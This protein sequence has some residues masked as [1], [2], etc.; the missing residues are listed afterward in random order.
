[1]I[2]GERPALVESSETLEGFL[3]KGMK[4]MMFHCLASDVAG[5]SMSFASL[6]C[7]ALQ[8]VGEMITQAG[9]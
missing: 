8:Y 5:L 3:E 6:S 4:L 7:F 1:M 2:G 9:C